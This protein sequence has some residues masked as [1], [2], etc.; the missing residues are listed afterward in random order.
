MPLYLCLPGK[1]QPE[2]WRHGMS[3]YAAPFPQTGNTANND[4]DTNETDSVPNSR[5]PLR[6]LRHGEVVLVDD[7]CVAYDTFW[8]RLRWPG[9]KAGF[10]GYL[11]LLDVVVSASSLSSSRGVGSGQGK[12]TE[13]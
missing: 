13:A 8:L 1:D 2:P 12:P 11:P 5:R 10:A 7:V 9:R 4:N 6:R 3:V